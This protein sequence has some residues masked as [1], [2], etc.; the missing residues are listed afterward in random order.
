MKTWVFEYPG[1]ALGSISA[2]GGDEFLSA[3]TAVQSTHV[4][5]QSIDTRRSATFAAA[6]AEANAIANAESLEIDWRQTPQNGDTIVEKRADGRYDV[7]R[8]VNAN[9][10]T[11]LA[12][13]TS[14][15]QAKQLAREALAPKGSS[16]WYRDHQA[17]PGELETC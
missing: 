3:V 10:P 7:R 14:L 8:I 12:G 15:D 4:A 5:S 2:A 1:G 13:V 17:A 6:V 11:V 16:I 9:R